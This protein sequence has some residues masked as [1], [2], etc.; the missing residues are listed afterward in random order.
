MTKKETFVAVIG[1]CETYK[2]PKALVEA[3]TEILEPKGGG[4][5]MD[6]DAVTKKDDQG[7]IVEIQC[8]LSGVFLPA[9]EEYFYADKSG[10]SKL[11]GLKRNSRQADK[12]KKAHEKSVATSEKAIM[13]DMLSG[14]LSPE[15]ATKKV[16]KL[17]AGT[18][19]YSTVGIIKPTEGAE[20]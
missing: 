7:N 1:L 13:E 18:P 4:P 5:V 9:T 12:I 19:D 17:R 3:L 2:A 6:I 11:N 20:A 16:T 8:S 10:K 15:E 14:S